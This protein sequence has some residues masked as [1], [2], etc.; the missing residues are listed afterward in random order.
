MAAKAK[1]A[2]KKST[3]NKYK[4]ELLLSNTRKPINL[5]VNE[6]QTILRRQIAQRT[7]FKISNIGDGAVYSDYNV[8]NTATK[9][10]Y[11]VALRSADNSLNYCS[12]YDFKTNQLGTCK[13]IEAV[14]TYINKKPA[15]RKM[16]RQS[17]TPAYSSM[18][19]E[20]R[21]ERKVMFR[22]GTDAVS[23]TH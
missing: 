18:Y 20:Y 14:L 2:R 15:W 16:L 23:Y 19:I 9:N 1:A 22:I 21:G 10:T 17:Y 5:S 8:Y 7:V 13:H 4:S 3:K 6:W 11:K 12:C